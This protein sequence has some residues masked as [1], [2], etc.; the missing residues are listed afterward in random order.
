VKRFRERFERDVFD[1][2]D[3]A[4][5]LRMPVLQPS[6]LDTSPQDQAT[7]RLV[8]SVGFDAVHQS[9]TYRARW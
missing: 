8:A 6:C 9:R 4:R 1:H 7:V 3:L 2:S 5:V